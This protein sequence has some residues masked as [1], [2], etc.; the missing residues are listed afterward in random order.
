MSPTPAASP[1]AAV[2]QRL[3]AVVRFRTFEPARKIIPAPRKPMPTTTFDATRVT[4]NWTFTA[5]W[6]VTNSEK[7]RVEMIPNTAAPRAT[8]MWVRSP[9][10]WS[11]TSR[12]RPTTAPS[13]A[14]ATRR[15]TASQLGYRSLTSPNASP[16]SASTTRSAIAPPTTRCRTH[17]NRDVDG[18]I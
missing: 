6:S 12:S 4:S 15:Q 7:P 14:A 9:A 3:A 13:A 8:V 5:R 11:S 2:T 10:G 18:D 17:E 16:R 1:N